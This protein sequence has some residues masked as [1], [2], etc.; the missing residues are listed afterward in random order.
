MSRTSNLF[1]VGLLVPVLASE[2]F[3]LSRYLVILQC[4]NGAAPVLLA[5]SQIQ[6]LS[7]QFRE[8]S[9]QT[10]QAPFHR[11]RPGVKIVDRF[12]GFHRILWASVGDQIV[13]GVVTD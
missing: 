11:L 3:R 5:P 4:A 7:A 12:P 13:T 9:F 2:P 1:L 6:H 10:F 8:F